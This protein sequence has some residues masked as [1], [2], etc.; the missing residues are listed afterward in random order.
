M[1]LPE[2]GSVMFRLQVLA[3]ELAQQ[4]PKALL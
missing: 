4:E 1:E 3:L 2:A